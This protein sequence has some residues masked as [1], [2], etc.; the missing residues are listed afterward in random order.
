MTCISFLAQPKSFSSV[1]NTGTFVK[2]I[3]FPE[4]LLNT[5]TEYI[6]DYMY[7]ISITQIRFDKNDSSNF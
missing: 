2:W 3:Y 5:L 6:T 7:N 4:I 1:P